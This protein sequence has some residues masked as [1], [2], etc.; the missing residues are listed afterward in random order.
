MALVNRND[1]NWQTAR[2]AVSKLLLRPNAIDSNF[3]HL[4]QV[5]DQFIKRLEDNRMGDGRI[6]NLP[7]EMYK[8]SAEGRK[9]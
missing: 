3:E 4:T 1:E 5:S 9:K 7:Y 8:W 2:P 6:R